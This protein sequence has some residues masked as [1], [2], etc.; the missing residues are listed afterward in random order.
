MNDRGRLRRKAVTIHDVATRAE[1]SIGTVSHVMSGKAPVAPTTR[2]RVMRAADELGYRPN[3]VARSLIL[4]QTHMIGMV[5]PD[6]ANPFFAE[7]AAAVENTARARDYCVV[8]GGV[9]N[10]P[11]RESIYIAELLERGVDGLLL[12]VTADSAA[13]GRVLGDHPAVAIDRVPSGWS[14]SS[15]TT[16]D[17]Q[18]L[19]LAVEHVV[20]L[21]HQRIG[22]L[23][24]DERL[25]LARGR[26]ASWREA[27]QGHRLAPVWEDAGPFTMESGESAGERLMALP[28][29][30][31][32]TAVVAANDLL[33]LGLLRAAQR[34]GVRVPEDLSIIGYDDIPYAELSM[35]ALTTVAQPIRSV[36]QRATTLLLDL[37]NAETTNARALQLA[38][39]VVVRQS[40]GPAPRTLRTR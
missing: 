12:A 7:L 27:M 37:M 1:T 25:P 39:W 26:R 14:A 18:A 2:D 11:E 4:Q 13:L 24:G 20:E 38:P 9:E 5:V 10:D 8:L 35:P 16:D 15:V 31:A 36:G 17:R 23:G 30:E 19:R 21:N 34:R 3:R 33:A 28:P 40:T 29:S 22:F 6:I 32:P